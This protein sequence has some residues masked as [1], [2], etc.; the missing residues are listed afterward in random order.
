M[1]DLVVE[2]QKEEEGLLVGLGISGIKN[3]KEKESPAPDL[4][5]HPD[6]GHPD[7]LLGLDHVT[8]DAISIGKGEAVVEAEAESAEG[9]E[10]V[11]E[12]KVEMH[13]EEGEGE[14]QVMMHTTENKK[15]ITR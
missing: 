15:L 5:L 12:V 10:I 11:V 1:R 3:Q 9:I 13:K 8:G 14:V 6:Q 7:H 2:N 4:A